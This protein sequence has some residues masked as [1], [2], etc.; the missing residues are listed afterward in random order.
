VSERLRAERDGPLFELLVESLAGWHRR[1]LRQRLK[2]GC[3][4]VNGVVIRR[5]DHALV[6][7]DE[8]AVLDEADAPPPVRAGGGITLLHID[9]ALVAVDKPAGL[10]AVKSERERERTALKLAAAALGRPGRPERLWPVHRLDRETSGVLLLARTREDCEAVRAEWELARKTYLAIVAGAPRDEEGTIDAPLW[11]DRALAVHV[12]RGPHAREAR[13]RWR[14]L[15]RGRAATL[16]EVE[17]ETGRRHQIRAHLAHVGHP[18]VGDE[19]YGTRAARMGLHALRLRVR[20]PAHGREH[21]FE[22]P[23]PAAFRALLR[24]PR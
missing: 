18:V 9:D 22:A 12:G 14:V 19:R 1:T 23:E 3:V 5:A 16:L 17:L 11:E 20:H 10:L 2:L 8:V 24:G 15:E 7:G 4:S 13:T 6:A 21:A